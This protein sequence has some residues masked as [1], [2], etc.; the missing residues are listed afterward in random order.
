[1]TARFAIPSSVYT[2]SSNR[3]V[4]VDISKSVSTAEVH[5]AFPSGQFI[6]DHCTIEY[7]TASGPHITQTSS[8]QDNDQVLVLL[9]ERLQPETLYDYTVSAGN[10][11]LQLKVKVEGVFITTETSEKFFCREGVFYCIP[12]TPA[13]LSQHGVQFYVLANCR[14]GRNRLKRGPI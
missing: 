5:C 9:L 13:C 1:M 10:D 12:F 8:H 4:D 3:L 14:S 11:T 7:W 2:G 6:S